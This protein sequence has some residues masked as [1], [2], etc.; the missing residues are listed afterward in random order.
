MYALH[1]QLAG[2]TLI[3]SNLFRRIKWWHASTESECNAYEV[4]ACSE[5]YYLHMCA[6][7][8]TKT[9]KRGEKK[10]NIHHYA[11]RVPFLCIGWFLNWEKKFFFSK[12][13]ALSSLAKY[14]LGAGFSEGDQK[15][16]QEKEKKDQKKFF[17]CHAWGG[18][19]WAAVDR[20]IITHEGMGFHSLEFSRCL[21]QLLGGKS[22]TLSAWVCLLGIRSA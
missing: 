9:E 14:Y 17:S 2:S 19:F 16:R 4:H 8:R 20:D 10:K 3:I 7:K 21:R 11:V 1:S 13:V 5:C 18:Q 15:T 6:R 22:D 12:Y